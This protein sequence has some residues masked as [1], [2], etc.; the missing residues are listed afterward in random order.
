MSE[1]ENDLPI[2]SPQINDDSDTNDE[3]HQEGPNSTP[4]QSIL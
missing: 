1:E 2:E 3:G 4:L